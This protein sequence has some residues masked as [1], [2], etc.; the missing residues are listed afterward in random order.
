MIPLPVIGIEDTDPILKD[1]RRDSM[2]VSYTTVKK[3]SNASKLAHVLFE[4]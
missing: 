3:E 4:S 1:Q 2:A